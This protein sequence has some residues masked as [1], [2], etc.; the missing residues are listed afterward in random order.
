LEVKVTQFK[1]LLFFPVLVLVFW[2]SVLL[3][4][5]K[6]EKH[7]GRLKAQNKSMNDEDSNRV[8]LAVET[9][10]QQKN[11]RYLFSDLLLQHAVE[12]FTGSG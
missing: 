9:H 1:P 7:D 6:R 8:T 5:R 12:A 2:L 10:R 4:S 3:C 11:Y